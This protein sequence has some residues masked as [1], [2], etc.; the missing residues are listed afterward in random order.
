M[1]F[2]ADQL[3]FRSREMYEAF[4]AFTSIVRS[5]EAGP[6][7]CESDQKHN[8]SQWK[9]RVDADGVELT[10][11]SFGG[12]TAVCIVSAAFD[13]WLAEEEGML[14]SPSFSVD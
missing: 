9:G 6:T 13:F 3:V 7:R 10:G 5:G 4:G 12:A 1:P 2:R 11:H 8:F 14:K